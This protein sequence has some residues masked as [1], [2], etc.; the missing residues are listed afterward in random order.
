VFKAQDKKAHNKFVA[1][2]KLLR[3]TENEGVSGSLQL[4]IFIRN[5]DCC[6]SRSSSSSGIAFQWEAKE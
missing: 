1:I 2:K 6:T 3:K 4:N 5:E